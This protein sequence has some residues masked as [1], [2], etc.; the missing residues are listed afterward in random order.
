MTTRGAALPLPG[1]AEG[2]E[3]R[4]GAGT[5]RVA[6]RLPGE[7]GTVVGVGAPAQR[8]LQPGREALRVIG[9]EDTAIFL[10][11]THRTGDDRLTGRH[12]LEKLQGAARV[13]DRIQ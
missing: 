2:V 4:R 12:V 13:G 10:D 8:L 7:Q 6:L 11:F 9:E 5:P 3:Q 1:R